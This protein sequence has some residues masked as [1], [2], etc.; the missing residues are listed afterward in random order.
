MTDPGAGFLDLPS[1]AAKPRALG[2]THVIDR[3][4]PLPAFDAMV[5]WLG[6]IAD[7]WKFGWGTAYIDQTIRNK[8]DILRRRQIV[9]CPGGTLL[10]IARLRRRV[11]RFLGWAADVG[12][13]AIEVSNG[14]T[15]MAGSDKRR[16]ISQASL[17][18]QVFSEVGSKDPAVVLRPTQWVSEVRADLEAGARWV[19]LEGRESG[20]V[21]LYDS[22]GRAREDVVDAVVAAADV[23]RLVFEAPRKEQQA[24]FIRRCG[25]NVNLG[26][27]S[28]DEALSLETMRLGLR[29]DTIALLR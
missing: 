21:G 8:V 4:A 11:D 1:R 22:E 6:D 19:L 24:W 20:T 14:A 28:P 23:E 26:N 12:F 16:L 9:A 25:S 27:L 13:A 15:R 3:G 18:F 29:A 10:E 5:E 17:H 2:L 7:V